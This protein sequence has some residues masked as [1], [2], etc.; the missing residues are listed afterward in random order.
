[1]SFVSTQPDFVVAAAQE[2]GT[3]RSA[4]DTA[5]SSA[6]ASTTGIAVA[7]QDEV[8]E[9]IT[10]LF[11][12][13]G[14]DFQGLT[15]RASG[16]HAEF[17]ALLGGGAGQYAAAEASAAAI[18]PSGLQGAVNGFVS[19]FAPAVAGTQSALTGA[20][21]GLQSALIGSGTALAGAARGFASTVE[22]GMAASQGIEAALSGAGQGFV[23]AVGG[24]P[25][26]AI[27]GAAAVEGAVHG[28]PAALNGAA[29]GFAGAW[30]NSGY[31]LGN[32]IT[33]ATH[34]WANPQAAITGAV[35]GFENAVFSS[36][37]GPSVMGTMAAVHGAVSN[38]S[39][40][41]ATATAAAQ[42]G[43]QTAFEG[44]GQGVLSAFDGTNVAMT[45]ALNNFAAA[46][47]HTPATLDQ[48]GIVAA[49]QNALAPI[50]GAVQGFPAY[51]ATVGLPYDTLF[52]NTGANLGHLGAVLQAHPFP[53]LNQFVANQFHFA[54][55]ALTGFGSL[56]ANAPAVLS[57]LPNTIAA[58]LAGFDPAGFLRYAIPT[59][60]SYGTTIQQ[61]FDAATQ[62]F[63]WNFDLLPTHFD[64][65][66][67][68]LLAGN[69]GGAFNQVSS[70][71]A[72]LFFN[73]V[74]SIPLASGGYSL[75][76][77]GTIGDLLPL[78]H[79]PGTIA[80]DF[81][82]LLPH[83]SIVAQMSQDF[84]NVLNTV[85]DTSLVIAPT[86]INPL[87]GPFGMDLSM[88]LPV[89]LNLQAAAALIPTVNAIATSTSA[90]TSAMSAGNLPGALAAALQAPAVVAN[91]FLNGQAA[92]PLTI[93]LGE[94]LSTTVELPISG[95]LVPQGPLT[96]TPVTIPPLGT[97]DVSITGTPLGGFLPALLNYAPTQLSMALGAPPITI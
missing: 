20:G 69:I 83:G 12:K 47:L 33:G 13:V 84:T 23:G 61:A 26:T 6:V 58:D 10:A 28:F 79:L 64:A 43:L 67:S 51:A 96:A 17:A 39:T 29:Q 88:G 44:A 90:F 76:L 85:T 38:F 72:G 32:A 18:L 89:A 66:W 87:A 65:A 95:F 94:G 63:A 74:E 11:N 91:G 27:A 71:F 86:N 4:L 48:A 82:N 30:T 9:V 45:G 77:T 53:V 57:N 14:A 41:A 81:T 8:S 34:A 56:V 31:A 37:V 35:S 68:D 54:Q 49:V 19:T 80:Q 78:L 59:A 40:A 2:L 55:E 3:V 25:A 36:P 93:P 97:V 42:A 60:Q 5:S 21:Q 62:S 50:E 75:A 73:G 15:A 1:M 70:G 52:A 24:F 46:V 16:F 22:S 92:L 7:A